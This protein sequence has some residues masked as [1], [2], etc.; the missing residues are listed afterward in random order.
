[1]PG[2]DEL[3]SMGA[4]CIIVSVANLS[5]GPLS[6]GTNPSRPPAFPGT[7]SPG[8]VVDLYGIVS[9]ESGVSNYISATSPQPGSGFSHGIAVSTSSSGL[10]TNIFGKTHSSFSFYH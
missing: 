2:P 9:Q 10:S 7:N 4:S 8:P 6:P 5:P 3:S 1:M